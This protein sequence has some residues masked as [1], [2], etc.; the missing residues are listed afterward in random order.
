ME[1]RT[2]LVL[3]NRQIAKDYFELTFAWPE[4]LQAPFPG[5]F[6]TIRMSES[7]VPLLRRPFAFSRF[8][9]QTLEAAL[10]YQKVGPATAIL[11]SVCAGD[12]LDMLVPLGNR[13]PAPQSGR[14]PVLVAGGIGMGPIFFFAQELLQSGVKPLLV[15]GARNVAFT[16]SMELFDSVDTIICTDD[17]SRGFA[18]T[19]VD[20]LRQHAEKVGADAE[21]YGCGPTGMLEALAAY[22]TES[23]FPLWVSLE[24]TMGCAV[25]ACMGCVVTVR[26][27]A[28]YA[29]V[30]TEGPVFAAEEIVW[31]QTAQPK[32]LT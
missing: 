24:Q 15:V 10:I 16:P 23:G 20:Y 26:G 25:G 17:G 27:P 19:V 29:R 9:A 2:V 8:N 22:S 13:F 28:Q 11:A 5:Q 32:Q 6:L 1:H 31:K 3:S 12:S 14:R 21:L 30:C 18:G 7:F 4:R